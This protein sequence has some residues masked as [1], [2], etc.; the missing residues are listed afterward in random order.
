MVAA[1]A[2]ASGAAAESILATATLVDVIAEL[3]AGLAFPAR[4][5]LLCAP[6]LRAALPPGRRC[7]WPG[8]A[9]GA[10]AAA[11]CG[12]AA[13][14]RVRGGRVLAVVA[15][16]D[17]M[18]GAA[19]EL[20]RR[21]GVSDLHVLY[22]ADEPGLLLRF[23]SGPAGGGWAQTATREVRLA[24]GTAVA[25]DDPPHRAEW[26][27]VH[28]AALPIDGRA[29]WPSDPQAAPRAAA[30]SALAWLAEREPAL[31]RPHRDAP[32]SGLPDSSAKLLAAAHLATEGRR[33]AWSLP[34]GTPLLGWLDELREIA[35][36]GIPLKLLC[37]PEDV[38]L[39]HLALLDGWWIAAPGDAAEAGAVLSWA[40]ATEDSVIIALPEVRADAPVHP[41]EQPWTPGSARRLAD[42]AAATIVCAAPSAPLALRARAALAG[43]GIDAGV[44][45]CTSLVPL[46][47][48]DLRRAAAQGPLV[49]V[50]AP[51]GLG[52]LV[53][54]AV[55][56]TGVV[57]A[58]RMPG[59]PI[60]SDAIVT[61]TRSVLAR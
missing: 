26:P 34:R 5:R 4:L 2:P 41:A 17:G 9:G 38:P 31:L 37:A 14:E 60:G 8:L 47:L 56:E 53:R 10:L 44:L 7:E 20:A 39:A 25:T 59:R 19:A 13:A 22:A 3:E 61:A 45:Q 12:V 46:P 16:D 11:A 33:V 35:R 28:L 36:R 24:P 43:S 42:G 1:R 27:P 52:R 58:T 15:R 18:L 55:G 48:P 29:P 51:D 30:E 50:D 23:G 32:W 21:L 54:E 57:L 40:L 6:E 49:V